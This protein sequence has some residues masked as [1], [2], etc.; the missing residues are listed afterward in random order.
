M[1][2][3]PQHSEEEA[4]DFGF[5]TRQVHAG[6]RPDPNTGARAVADLPDHE[7]R[8]RGSGVGCRV[9]QPSGVREHLLAHHESDGGGVRGAHGEPR[10]RL[11]CGGI[12][13]RDRGAGGGVVHAAPAGRPRRLLVCALRRHRQPVQAPAAQDERRPD[14]GRPGRR[15]CLAG[16]APRQHQA[17]LRRDDRQPGRQRARHR[18]SRRDRARARGAADRRQHVRDALSLPAD[19]V[20]RRHRHPLGHQVHRRPRHEHRRRRR[21][22]GGVQLVERPLPGD[23]RPLPRLPRAAVPRDV[24]HLRLLHEAARRDPP[25]SRRR[26]EPLQRVPLPA[27]AR[28]VVAADGTPRRERH[29]GRHVPRVA[30]AHL[31]RHLSGPRSRAA[32]ARSSTGTCREAPAPSSRSTARAAARRART[33]SAASRSGRTWRTSA[34][35]RASSSI[36]RARRTA[37][38]ATRSSGRPGSAPE[39]S[40]SR[41]AP[42]RSTT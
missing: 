22:I 9:L 25:R 40:G 17:S 34:T 16:G 33:S 15:R 31:E 32:F 1:T 7:L 4:R 14:L 36:R 21:R 37:S 42:S 10:G 19:R 5:E 29:G 12:C 30:G 38:S 18:G 24:R 27:R 13:E 11:W 6:Q 2:T 20:G 28:D 8:V 41:S 3:G 39:R 26:D 35:R 23:R